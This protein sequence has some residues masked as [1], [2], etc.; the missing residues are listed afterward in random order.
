MVLELNITDKKFIIQHDHDEV[1]PP[2]ILKIN[3]LKPVLRALS[4]VFQ[5][6]YLLLFLY[7]FLSSV[8][9]CYY[10]WHKNVQV[11]WE[12]EPANIWT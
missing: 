1:H 10:L 8:Q 6:A 7:N 9:L 12:Q 2:H 4:L 11:S 5:V 3:Y